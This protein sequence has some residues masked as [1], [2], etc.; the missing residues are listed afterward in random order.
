MGDFK[1]DEIQWLN[2]DVNRLDELRSRFMGFEIVTELIRTERENEYAVN[3]GTTFPRQIRTVNNKIVRDLLNAS[4]QVL[5]NQLKTSEGVFNQNLFLTH[6]KETALSLVFESYDKAESVDKWRIIQFVEELSEIGSR[7]YESA[8][9]NLGILYFQEGAEEKARK[10][11]I[12]S[13]LEFLP[14][15]TA[16]PFM[17]LFNGEKAFLKLIDNRSMALVMNETFAVIGVL[18]KKNNGKSISSELEELIFTYNMNSVLEHVYGDFIDMLGELEVKVL[19]EVKKQYP[20]FTRQNVTQI[21]EVYKELLLENIKGIQLSNQSRKYPE[22][23]YISVDNNRVDF[24]TQSRMVVSLVNGIWK[25]RHYDLFVASILQRLM[26]K[27]LPYYAAISPKRFQTQMKRALDGYIRLFR[28]FI[29]LSRERTSSVYLIIDI[30]EILHGIGESKTARF[31]KETGFLHSERKRLSLFAIKKGKKNSN[32]IDLDP[33][34]IKSMSAVDGAVVLDSNL[35]VLS[36][37][38]I[39][40]VSPGQSYKGTFGTG[41]TAAQFASKRGIAVKVSEDGDITLFIDEEK[42]LKL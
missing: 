17:K 26:I 21:V 19:R 16:E 4:N 22:F 20:E 35:N 33:Y 9:V 38:E 6:I 37:G 5:E 34:L 29:D 3:S 11:F 14:F 8:S 10:S 31:L 39:I 23:V 12:N 42:I 24:Y 40:S 13:D 15:D 18:R 30:P 7:T 1:T 25:M 41:S 2:D 28:T 32:L 36:F 27:K